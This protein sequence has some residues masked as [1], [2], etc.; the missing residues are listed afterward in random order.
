MK[1][2]IEVPKANST[3]LPCW[4]G[5][6]IDLSVTNLTLSDAW[7]CGSEYGQ[8]YKPY[9]SSGNRRITPIKLLLICFVFLVKIGLAFD[10]ELM[11]QIN[12]TDGLWHDAGLN[13]TY[14]NLQLDEFL[15][16]AA[17][18]IADNNLSVLNISSGIILSDFTLVS[19]NS[20]TD[21]S[22]FKR[23][24]YCSWYSWKQKQAAQK[25]DWWSPWYP[26][27]CCVWNQLGQGA[28]YTMG[29][30]YEY[31]WSIEA[32]STISYKDVESSIGFSVSKT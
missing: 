25:G 31:S 13:V 18:I 21:V 22:I 24:V 32:G 27:S 20:E 6:G 16:N 8:Y 9:K 23:D 12:V 2:K 29:Y 14:T 7:A 17:P 26:I 4:N 28:H 1:S 15:T 10:S 19:N 11:K 30:E 3:F 5:T